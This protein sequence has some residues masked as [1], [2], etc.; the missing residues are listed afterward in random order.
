M[1][2]KCIKKIEENLYKKYIYNFYLLNFNLFR[3]YMFC[4]NIVK[5]QK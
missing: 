1:Y 2:L 3:L 4:Y 5:K